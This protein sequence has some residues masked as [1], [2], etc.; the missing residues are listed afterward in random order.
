MKLFDLDI[1]TPENKVFSGQVQSVTV[2][3][4]K[5]AF[6]VLYNHA[7]IIST[8]EKGKL[9]FVDE[10]GKEFDYVIEGGVVEVLKNKMIVL[11]EKIG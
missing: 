10:S 4:A 3:G 7:P 8:L 11:A 9:K 5:G 1:V 6:Q 2:P